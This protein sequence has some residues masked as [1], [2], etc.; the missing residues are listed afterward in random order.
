M[1]A[2]ER[3]PIV[4]ENGNHTKLIAI[5]GAWPAPGKVSK[6]CRQFASLNKKLAVSAE[7]TR[8]STDG[9]VLK[10][11]PKTDACVPLFLQCL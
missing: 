1:K 11:Y 9:A 7:P 6:V 4:D 3:S 2:L 8:A 5:D 10:R